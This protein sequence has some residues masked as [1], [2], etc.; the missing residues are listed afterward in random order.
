MNK[1]IGLYIHIPF[2]KQKCS[3]CDFYSLKLK[4]GQIET[5]TRS[6]IKVVSDLCKYYGINAFSTVYI[7]GGT[8]SLLGEN[9]IFLLDY[10][11]DNFKI[12]KG[13]EITAEVNPESA[14]EFLPFA[15]AA[16]VNRISFGIQSSS[17]EM[18]KKLGRLHTAEDV[19]QA[20]K[21][22]KSLG[23]SNISG[24]IMI[25]LPGED[26]TALNKDIDFLLSLD[27]EHISSY[28]LKKEEGTPLYIKNTPLPDDDTVADLYLH[29]SKRLTLAGYSH[30]EI[31]NF[32]R[33][34]FEGRHNLSYWQD[35]EY[36]GVGPAAHSFINGKRFY[37]E[38]D[39]SSFLQ[40]PV[41]V[42]EDIGGTKTEK[43]MLSLR[44]SEGVR[45]K[46]FPFL[47]NDK[48]KEKIARF[49]AASCLETNNGKIHLT[50]KGFLI[51]N[52]IISELIDENL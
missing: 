4:K 44:L 3:Y 11:K 14:G 26:I 43:F 42:F 23:F 39:L 15:A 35:K 7:G 34:G 40:N 19:K 10:I 24:D 6:L 1:A 29:M 12:S 32:A 5:Y 22:A 21:L 16:G 25:G 46:D 2:C 8:P 52:Y 51:S 36:L 38:R 45:I 33:A 49:K 31:S 18:L 50:D 13:A 37:F 9:I 30:Y 47:Q 48:A 20:V 17:D 28:I 41:T 27:I